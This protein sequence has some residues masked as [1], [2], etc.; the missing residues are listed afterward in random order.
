MKKVRVYSVVLI[1]QLGQY[2]ITLE[3]IDGIRLIPIW[4]GPAEGMAIGAKLEGQQ[5]PRPLTHDLMANILNNMNVKTKKVTVTELK[6]STFYAIITFSHNN[7]KIEMDSRPSDAIALAVRTNSPIF[8]DDAV[9][10]K[11]PVIQ[12]PISEKEIEDFKKQLKS[13]KPEDF[14]KET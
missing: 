12:K 4:V 9:F 1:P 8:V 3:E 13:L 2:L 7:K 11:C 10:K 6:N 5:F 14:F